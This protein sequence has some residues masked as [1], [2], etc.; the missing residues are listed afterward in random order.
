M[1]VARRSQRV[2]GAV[3][4]RLQDG[5]ALEEVAS[6]VQSCAALLTEIP[7]GLPFSRYTSLCSFSVSVWERIGVHWDDC[8]TAVCITIAFLCL[9]LVQAMLYRPFS[10]P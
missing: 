1:L 4:C 2:L 9:I 7:A 5:K 6:Q 8:P 10:A 3:V